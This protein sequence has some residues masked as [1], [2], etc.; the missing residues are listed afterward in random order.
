MTLIADQSDVVAFL[1]ERL[2]DAGGE[3]RLVSTHASL[4]LLGATRVFKL[5]RAVR[6]A[7]LDFSTPQRRLDLCRREVELNRR[8][9][10]QLYLGAHAITREQDGSLAF[11]GPGALVDAVVE[12]RRFSDADLLDQRAQRGDL[13]PAMMT[14]LARSIAAFHAAALPD[15]T[16]GG[17]AAMARVVDGADAELRATG[18]LAPPEADA[19]AAALRAALTRAA[20][21]L[22]ARRDAG[23]LRR[24]HGDLTLRNICVLDGEATPFDCLEFDETLATVDVL[25]DLAFLLMDLWRRGRRDAANLVFNRYL[26]AADETD[27]LSLLPFFMATRAAVRAH[28]AARQ[29]SEAHGAEARTLRAEARAHVDLAAALLAPAPAMLVAVGGFSGSGKSTLAA[30]LA[31]DLGAPPGAR[32][33]SSDRL[34]K[35]MHGVAAETRLPADAYAPEISRA[36][37]AAQR[38]QA[39]ATLKT[40]VA[41]VADAV[42]DRADAREAIAQVA[43]DAAVAFRGL[44]LDAPLDAL[45][46]RVEARKGDASDATVAVLRA[47]AQAGAGAVDWTRL[48]ATGDRAATLRAARAALDRDAASPLS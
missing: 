14:R 8:T 21:L 44:W 38:E 18:L 36:V 4:V 40:G 20:P 28:I 19:L 26:D 23:K 13:P 48:D 47:Q 24:C 30:A 34:R 27:G 39:A 46:G 11:D 25:Y 32:V 2:R 10:P 35:A 42:F 9:A 17:A 5:K 7:F 22:D 1:R 45:A 33:L 43:R 3:P 12:M 31:P 6:Y 29:A 41:V 37:Y 15:T 16:R